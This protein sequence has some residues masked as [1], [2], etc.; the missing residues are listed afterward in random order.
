MDGDR[1]VNSWWKKIEENLQTSAEEV[2]GFEEQKNGHHGL[3]MNVKKRTL[4]G[5]KLEIKCS[6]KQ[7]AEHWRNIG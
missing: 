1:N 7:P 6:K 3:M 4:S 2:L 5:K